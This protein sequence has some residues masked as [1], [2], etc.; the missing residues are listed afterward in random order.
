MAGTALGTNCWIGF[1]PETT[2]G[3]A[4]TP[5]TK[6]VEITKDSLNFEY[7]M[8]PFSTLRRF[9]SEKVIPGKINVSGSIEFPLTWTGAEQLLKAAFGALATTGPVS[10]VYTQTFTLTAALPSITIRKN[11]D[12]GTTGT[13]G[14]YDFAGCQIK[15]LSFKLAVEGML[16][17]TAEIVGASVVP[18]SS[19]S[20]TYVV[21]DQIDWSQLSTFQFVG[22]ST[23]FNPQ[24]TEINI[25]LENT[26]AEDRYRMGST[27]RRGL[28]RGG[29]R[30]VSVKFT[31][32]FDDVLASMFPIYLQ[33]LAFA[34]SIVFTAPASPTRTLTFTVPKLFMQGDYPSISDKSVVPV[35]L[36][37][38]AKMS[39]AEGDEITMVLQNQ[40]STP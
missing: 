15:K 13:G 27:N 20:P 29:E 17:C 4:V 33:R 40:T 28:G 5:P 36:N 9:S 10:T 21:F 18:G 22:N 24:P 38:D 39:S 3:V 11:V 14:V 6:F 31:S 23:T 8:K 1:A 35:T 25:D 30:K 7:P 2:Y 19:S 34:G 37:F 32:E 16:M 12:F 26:L